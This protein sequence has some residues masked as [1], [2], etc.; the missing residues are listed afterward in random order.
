MKPKMT[1]EEFAAFK[2]SARNLVVTAIRGGGYG[3]KSKAFKIIGCPWDDFKRHIE[4]Q[5]LPKMRW[6][7]YGKWHIDHRIPLKSA[8]DEHEIMALL[9]YLNLQ[10][11]WAKDNLLKHA[12]MPASVQLHLPIRNSPT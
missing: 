10:P 3:E 1:P 2:R 11:L 6:E 5:F 7:N 12:T 8:K 9:H 4:S